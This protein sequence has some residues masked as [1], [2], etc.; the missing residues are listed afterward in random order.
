LAAALFIVFVTGPCEA[1]VPLL[2][3]S[4]VQGNSVHLGTTVFSF[5]L[6]T[7]ATMLGL[8]SVGFVGL[9]PTWLSRGEGL[10]HVSTGLA[11]ALS[12]AGVRFLGL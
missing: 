8:V 6:A 10:L 5:S 9:R 11:I 2:F 4:G 3:A 1:L 7:V 12:G